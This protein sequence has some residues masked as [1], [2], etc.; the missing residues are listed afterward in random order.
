MG[1]VDGDTV[2]NDYPGLVDGAFRPTE[3]VAVG[4]SQRSIAEALPL[5]NHGVP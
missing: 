5:A 4:H 3:D 2:L 1:I